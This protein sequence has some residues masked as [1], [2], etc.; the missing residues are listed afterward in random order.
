MCGCTN[1]NVPN[2]SKMLNQRDI[3]LSAPSPDNLGKLNNKEMDLISKYIKLAKNYFEFGSG[4][5]TYEAA[6]YNNLLNIVSVESDNVWINAL[7][8]F[9]IIKNRINSNTLTF[10]YVDINVKPNSYGYPANNSKKA[11]WVNYS[12][13]ILAINFVPDLILVDGRFRVA[14]TLNSWKKM[15]QNS[16]L[17]IRNYTNRKQYHV[18][19][20]FFNK[21]ETIGTSQIF[22]KRK[23]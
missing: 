20:E 21:I 15:D 14:S 23:I 1:K 3:N 4:R 16:I 13:A 9:D 22:K 12:S 11:N 6:Q 19:E 10:N 17:I 8:V 5:S 2:L 18:I 7:S